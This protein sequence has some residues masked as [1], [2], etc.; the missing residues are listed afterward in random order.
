M[1]R[2]PWPFAIGFNFLKAILGARKRAHCA[3]SSASTATNGRTM[4][5]EWIV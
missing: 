2:L 3:G 5:D 4:S 1:A